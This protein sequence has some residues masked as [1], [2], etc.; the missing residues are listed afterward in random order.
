MGKNIGLGSDLVNAYK[1]LS[2]GIGLG[3]NSI[4]LKLN[5]FFSVS[6]YFS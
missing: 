4:L 3:C 2:K 1:C 5:S 6:L